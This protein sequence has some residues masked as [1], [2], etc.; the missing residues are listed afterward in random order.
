VDPSEFNNNPDVVV[1]F[2]PKVWQAEKAFTPLRGG[3][4]TL[5]NKRR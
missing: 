4:K 5:V 3:S 2:A 1:V